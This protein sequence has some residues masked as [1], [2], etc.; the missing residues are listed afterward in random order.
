MKKWINILDEPTRNSGLNTP[1]QR[2]K[3]REWIWYERHS[4][5][6]A[7]ETVEKNLNDLQFWN[8]IIFETN[9]FQFS[10]A[11]ALVK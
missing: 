7:A 1:N 6:L 4:R 2:I 11:K 8:F 3:I 10:Y 9:I 5:Y